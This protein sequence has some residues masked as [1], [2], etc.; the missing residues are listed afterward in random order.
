MTVWNSWTKRQQEDAPNISFPY[1]KKRPIIKPHLFS[2][3]SKLLSH[4]LPFPF[5]TTPPLSVSCLKILHTQLD[6]WK[7]QTP[8]P[9]FTQI[10]ASLLPREGKSRSRYSRA[11]SSHWLPLQVGLF[12]GRVNMEPS[13]APTLKPQL[14]PSGYCSDAQSDRSW[15]PWI[16][17]VSTSL[18][19]LWV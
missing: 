1:K 3:F 7:T 19:L 8:H 9:S 4:F 11:F 5:G 12:A 13:W 17:S 18:M 14:T 16:F 10:K 6:R 2:H 15:P